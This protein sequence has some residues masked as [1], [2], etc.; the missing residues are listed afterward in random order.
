MPQTQ[1][2]ADVFQP[3]EKQI[4]L[5]E[6]IRKAPSGSRVLLGYGGAAGG[7]KTR[8]LVELAIDLALSFPGN[9]I[10]VGRKDFTDLRE[11]TMAQFQMHCPREI[12]AKSN[13]SEHWYHIREPHWPDGVYSRIIFR[14]LKDYLGLGS[15]EYGAVLIDE[16]GEVPEQSA[17][18]LLSRLR[19]RLPPQVN[20]EIK[21]VFAAASNP[22]PGWFKKWF[23][24]RELPEDVLE[25]FSAKVYFIPALAK[26]NP[27]LDPNYEAFLR[28]VYPP[29]WVRRF[30]DGSWDVYERQVYPEFN[31]DIHRWTKKEIPLFGRLVGGLDFGEPSNSAHYSA[32]IVAGVFGNRIIRV[33]EF[34]EN[35]PNVLERQ[36]RWMYEQEEKWGVH[37]TSY[38]RSRRPLPIQWCADKSQS[39]AI[40][41]LRRMGFWV[42]PSRGGKDSIKAGITLVSHRLGRDATGLPGSFYLPS[43]KN[44]ER[45]MQLYRWPE[46]QEDEPPPK[47]PLQVND[48]LMD[49]D[50]YMHELLDSR[51]MFG[52]PQIEY[53]RSFPSYGPSGGRFDD[54][55]VRWLREG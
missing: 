21:Y 55:I 7:G 14:E 42:I 44:F 13:L 5:W 26:D 38:K 25:G 31:P 24:D 1:A 50:R 2:A 6:Y 19:W 40:Q 17:L 30:L 35:G 34:K 4:L 33:A 32:G 48:D 15:E 23:V 39:A 36:I 9:R 12:I 27:Y 46:R 10:I 41:L 43:L 54:E 8:A 37:T 16:A 47:K 20:K 22:W 11:T 28:S 3:T 18:M 49:A 51:A 53:R 29:E 45:D 52:D